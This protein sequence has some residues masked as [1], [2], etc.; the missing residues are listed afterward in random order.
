MH[1]SIVGPE[2]YTVKK[3]ALKKKEEEKEQTLTNKKLGE[4][5]WKGFRQVRGPKPSLASWYILI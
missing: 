1:P 5:C 2:I 4:V 3:R